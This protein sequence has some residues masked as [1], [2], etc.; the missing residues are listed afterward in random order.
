MK[1][2]CP[3]RRTRVKICGITRPEDGLSAV[4]LGADALGL[5][6]YPGS[7]RHV[8]IDGARKII[9]ALPPFVTVVG[10]F[11]D[12]EA[13]DVLAVINAVRID[14][15]QFHGDETEAF[16]VRFG[17]PYIKALRMRPDVDLSAEIA[18]Y[19]SACGFLVDAWHPDAKGG[20]G[21]CFD[22]RI[23][24]PQLAESLILAGGL[25]PDNVADAL[26]AVRPYALDVSSGVEAGKG[27]K[28]VAKM[29]AFL[30]EVNEFDYSLHIG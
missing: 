6:F 28:D 5:V 30:R 16:C 7:P 23:L 27:I 29:A 21:A 1:I 11:V 10:L 18:R 25:S 12:A 24:P 22:W 2:A 8:G 3:F 13:R 14:L 15:L 26:R 19:A 9:A 4:L 17:K 20:T